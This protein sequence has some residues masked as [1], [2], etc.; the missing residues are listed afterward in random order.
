MSFG[1]AGALDVALP[2]GALVVGLKVTS[3]KGTWDCDVSW[4]EDL[5][6]RIPN[7][8]RGHVWGSEFL[9]P[10]AAE[11]IGLHKATGCTIVDMESQCAAEVAAEAKI[12]LAVIRVVCDVANHNVP[13]LVMS[14]INPDGST[15]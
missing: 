15:M 7:A 6:R 3:L 8:L 12:P 10:T 2:V 1:V 14:A 9:V 5:A 4:G 13:P 11:K